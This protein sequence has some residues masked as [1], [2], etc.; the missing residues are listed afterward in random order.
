MTETKPA[1][2]P[3]KKSPAAEAREAEA[4]DGYVTIEHC[5]VTLR[6]PV[7]GK[8]PVKAIDAFRAGDNY[9][10]TQHLVGPEQWKLLADAGMT[11]DGLDELGEK[12]KAASGN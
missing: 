11:A 3:R 4:E 10:G 1:P 6:L 12:L 5:G 8:V 2:K 9:G 7:G